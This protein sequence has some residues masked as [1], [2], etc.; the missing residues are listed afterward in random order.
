LL[1]ETINWQQFPKNIVTIITKKVDEL[2]K[3]PG[4]KIGFHNWTNQ[5]WNPFL[6]QEKVQ[7]FPLQHNSQ[8]TNNYDADL[9]KANYELQVK[10]VELFA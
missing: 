9:L 4:K 8:N 1:T 3:L 5:P 6:L 2:A 10:A 7:F